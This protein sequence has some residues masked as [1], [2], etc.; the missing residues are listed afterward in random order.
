MNLYPRNILPHKEVRKFIV[1]FYIVGFLGFVIPFSRDIFTKITPLALLL[2]TYLLFVFHNKL[3]VKDVLAFLLI[4][5]LGFLTEAIGVNTGLIFGHYSYGS[6]LGP[7]IW[8]TPLLIGINWLFLAYSSLAVAE[9]ISNKAILQIAIAPTLMLIY[10]LVLEQV[11]PV[12]D[13]WTWQD[14]FVPLKNFI[15]WW[16]IGLTFAGILRIFK[17]NTNNP[18]AFILLVC[19]FAFFTLL[20]LFSSLIL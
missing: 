1:I 13:M 5:I 8:G 7:A 9:K 6:A 10:D 16:C 14:A 18:L 15:S 12:M 17:T 2:C 3:L 11:A 20:F 19:Q 4:Y